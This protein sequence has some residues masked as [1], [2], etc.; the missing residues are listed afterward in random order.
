MRRWVSENREFAVV[1]GG[2]AAL[3]VAAPVLLVTAGYS[4]AWVVGNV[5]TLL[6]LGGWLV[7]LRW[8]GWT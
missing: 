5:G 7:W 1:L 6:W 8:K 2:Q 4:V 3:V